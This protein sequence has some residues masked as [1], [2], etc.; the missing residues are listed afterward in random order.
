MEDSEWYE[1]QRS[2]S[3][4]VKSETRSPSRAEGNK[5]GQ[6]QGTDSDRRIESVRNTVD[7]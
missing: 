3:F 2:L 4:W 5:A 6:G 1:M 7:K